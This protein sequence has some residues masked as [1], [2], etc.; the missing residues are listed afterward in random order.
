[1]MG[2]PGKG[3]KSG[4]RNKYF[5]KFYNDSFISTNNSE[6]KEQTNREKYVFYCSL[7]TKILRKTRKKHQ[8]CKITFCDVP[9]VSMLQSVQRWKMVQNES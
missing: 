2:T 7:F 3:D 4:L 8:K 9:T 1:M 6:Q 5:F